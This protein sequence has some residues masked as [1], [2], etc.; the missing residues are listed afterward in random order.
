MSRLDGA[1]GQ[2]GAPPVD[3]VAAARALLSVE[4]HPSAPTQREFLE[5]LA[6]TI[7]AIDLLREAL[8]AFH[9]FVITELDPAREHDNGEDNDSWPYSIEQYLNWPEPRIA[10]FR[11][12]YGQ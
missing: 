9:L 8:T 11:K 4:S 5:G 7:T 6:V 1:F 10:A 2:Y 3:T 12:A